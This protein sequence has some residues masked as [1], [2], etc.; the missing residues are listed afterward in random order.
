M[1]RVQVDDE[2]WQ[3]FR[4]IAGHRPISEILGE[5]VEREVRNAQSA[6]LREGRLDD[7][8]IVKALDTAR[9]L[10]VDLAATVSRLESLRER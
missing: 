6:R 3:Q 4:G 9:E 1:A 10:Q 2:T 5:L 7:I 8:Q